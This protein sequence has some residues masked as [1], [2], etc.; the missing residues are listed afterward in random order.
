MDKAQEVR[1]RVIGVSAMTMTTARRVR[2]VREDIDRR[3]LGGR[4]QLAVGDA[5]F[6]VCAPLAFAAVSAAF[7]ARLHRS[8]NE[9]P[10]LRCL[11]LASARDWETV[12]VP[13]PDT[14]RASS[15]FGMPSGTWR[16]TIAARCPSPW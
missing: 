3:G 7:R 1:A 2:S 8:P 11:A 9:V 14:H 4:I 12:V 5:V 6:V 10:S 16:P 13:D 15:S